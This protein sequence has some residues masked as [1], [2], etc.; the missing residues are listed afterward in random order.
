MTLSHLRILHEGCQLTILM[1]RNLI[2][3]TFQNNKTVVDLDFSFIYHVSK[4]YYR[5]QAGYA[6]TTM[7]T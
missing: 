7:I 6:H 5:G 4:V 1:I 3:K 2:I